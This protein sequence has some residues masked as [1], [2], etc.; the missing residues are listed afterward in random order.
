MS[1]DRRDELADLLHRADDIA[2]PP[3]APRDLA[4]R[5]RARAHARARRQ[6]LAAV[7]AVPVLLLGASTLVLLRR[8]S[9]PKQPAPLAHHRTVDPRPDPT[10]SQDDAVLL[11]EAARLRT[12][13]DLRLSVAEGLRARARRRADA[14][15]TVERLVAAD[16]LPSL[17]AEREK[18][19]LTLLDHADRLRRDLN[20]VND[21][22]AAYRRTIEL[23]PGTRWAAVAKRRIDELNPD[24]RIDK[25]PPSIT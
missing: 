9:G 24:A 20:Q 23:F 2:P 17:D 25:N 6:R 15:R 4:L 12:D 8:P 5:V 14:A 16:A 7:A 3:P 19:A 22:L 11:A 13:A 21:A 18:A 10:S 1:L